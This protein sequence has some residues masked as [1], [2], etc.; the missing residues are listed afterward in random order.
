MWRL[1]RLGRSLS[2]LVEIVTRLSESEIGLCSLRESID[3]TTAA[4]RLILHL[5]ATLAE[6]EAD[7]VC[8]RTCAGPEAAR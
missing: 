7:R 8:E 1:E 5:F 6:F 3:T 4:G 2:A